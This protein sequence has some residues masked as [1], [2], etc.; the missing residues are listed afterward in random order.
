MIVSLLKM[1][2]VD[3]APQAIPL[4]QKPDR[5]PSHGA[6]LFYAVCRCVIACKGKQAGSEAGCCGAKGLLIRYTP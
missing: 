3:L 6:R 2:A 5:L 4:R 1:T